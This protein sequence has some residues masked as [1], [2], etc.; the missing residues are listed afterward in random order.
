MFEKQYIAIVLLMVF[1]GKLVTVDSDIIGL[2]LKTD[3]VVLLNPFCEKKDNNLKETV[4][5][6]ENSSPIQIL[7]LARICSNNY[8][9]IVGK[10]IPE[11][12]DLDF[13]KY[14]Y[15]RPLVISIHPGK[16]YPPPKYSIV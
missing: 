9:F 1:S 15:I 5:N 6:I 2:M 14:V 10:E 12:Q 8:H 3:Q 16:L 11:T 7:K 4:H 13:R